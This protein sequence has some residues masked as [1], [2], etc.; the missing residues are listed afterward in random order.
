MIAT[1]EQVP[2]GP[3][4]NPGKAYT[5][6]WLMMN[7]KLVKDGVGE[8]TWPDGSIYRGQFVQDQMEGTGQMVQASGDVYQGQWKDNQ[9][10]GHGVF[11][12]S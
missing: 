12:D 4:E 10:N 5:G 6:Q 9:A 1:K 2:P 3:N 7:G 8:M 11:V